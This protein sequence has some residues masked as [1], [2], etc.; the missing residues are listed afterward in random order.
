MKKLDY[1]FGIAA[2]MILFVSVIIVT[3]IGTV[4]SIATDLFEEVSI[5][6]A[7][8]NNNSSARN[9]SDRVYTSFQNSSQNMQL[10]AQ[11]ATNSESI[12]E[13]RRAIGNTLA[14][15]DDLISFF[16]YQVDKKGLP[17]LVIASF[18][19]TA[20]S[21]Y[22]I[23]KD[24]LKTKPEQ[25]LF[26][27]QYQKPDDF[28]V[29]NSAP[30]TNYPL[31][32]LSFMSEKKIDLDKIS[33]PSSHV[34]KDRWI[35][36]A[37]LRHSSILRV[38]PKSEFST[39]YLLSFDGKLLAHSKEEFQQF[40][41]QDTSFSDVPIVEKMLTTSVD[42][43]QMEYIDEY[44]EEILGA[45]KK[46]GV[47][48]LGVVSQIRKSEALATIER[49]RARS[50]WVM[51]II[52]CLAFFVN[53]AFSNSITE[54]IQKLFRATEQI[55]DGNFDVKLQSSSTDE[56]GALSLAFRDM[57]SG[58]KERDKIK[59]A[60][61]KFHSKE[62]AQ[63]LLSGDIKLG[64]ERKQATVFFSDI[65]GFTSMSEK[66]SPDQV[67]AMLNDY[68]TEMV[69]IIFKWE[70]VV[71]K[72]IGDAIMAVWGVPEVK[73][74]DAYN[75]VRASIEMREYM[76]EFNKKRQEA[77]TLGLG[78]GIGLHSGEVLAGNI[79]SEERLEYTII[80]DTVNQAS[81]IE[82]ANKSTGSDI[83]IS[84]QTYSLIRDAGIVCGPAIA[85]RAKGKTKDVFV[86]QVIGY[87]DESGT[88]VTIFNNDKI[89]EI[90]NT[91]SVL[92]TEEE[93]VALSQNYAG[94]SESM[95]VVAGLETLKTSNPVA[96]PVMTE[97]KIW[98][99]TDSQG[100]NP[101]G[102]YAISELALKVSHGH[103]SPD[104]NYAF[105]EGDK[106]LSRLK[107]VEGINR[108]ADMP[109][110]QQA[111]PQIPPQMG[112]N[113]SSH[114]FVHGPHGQ[115]LGPYT[116]EQLTHMVVQGSLTRT[117]F[118][119]QPGMGNWIYLYQIPGFDR[120]DVS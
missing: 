66:M 86:H 71:D 35:F 19:D 70:G 63:K 96:P 43:Q 77:G 119:W 84:A 11:F 64:G 113:F 23:D 62:I 80:G 34:Y 110:I 5:T 20:L 111:V 107:D 79:G 115:H 55:V 82:S 15:T 108:R 18:S 26:Y 47:A 109:T 45:Y 57:A 76:L 117:T 60:F 103:F 54:P 53:F 46:I 85:I 104:N 83:L 69:R 74:K 92:G 40:L 29:I 3:A 4:V 91:T 106:S 59:N 14:G 41:F 52:V 120:R 87:K 56:I 112:Q 17:K 75:A 7:Q 21:E 101:T 38:F 73:P 89:N 8:E 12:E 50:L 28:L 49:V 31:Y 100:L 78:I 98:F 1:S 114:W 48:G 25:N 58:L 97:P 68:M 39:S 67:V 81:R 65:R 30:F 51:I 9:L 10:M 22:D 24:L 105:R 116:P 2:K 99:V 94:P 88:L 102:P 27:H 118:V 61:G 44:D 93:K 16:A 42:S 37:E 90:E 6:R 13:A 72:Y 36:R 32:S 95:P 33:N